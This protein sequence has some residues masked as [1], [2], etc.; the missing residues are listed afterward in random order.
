MTI[1]NE[2]RKSFSELIANEFYNNRMAYPMYR[3]ID[4]CLYEYGFSK[5]KTYELFV[6]G[7]EKKILHNFSRMD[8]L[9]ENLLSFE[10]ILKTRDELCEEPSQKGEITIILPGG[11]IIRIPVSVSGDNSVVIN[12][13]N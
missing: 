4:K 5:D 10:D 7:R 11:Q 6:S 2:D 12:H 9:A 3:L 1:T 8:K 13:T